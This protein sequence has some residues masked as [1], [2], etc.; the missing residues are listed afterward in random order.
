MEMI[1]AKTWEEAVRRHDASF[2]GAFVYAVR[3]TGIYCRPGCPSRAP[4]PE[5][6]TFFSTPEAAEAAGFRACKKCHPHADTKPQNAMIARVCRQIEQAET[7]LSLAELAG[8]A[9]LSP[10]H[11]HRKFRAATGLTPK[12]YAAAIRTRREAAALQTA[13]SVTEALYEAGY[14]SASRFYDGA[15][16]RLGMSPRAV[17]Q[18]GAAQKIRV[19]TA[20][21]S[22]GAVLVAATETGLCA[23]QLGDDAA[24]LR[25]DFCARFA[26]ADISADPRLAALV[27]DVVT[28]IETPGQAR[29]L[30]LDIRGTAF[31]RAVW[32]ALQ[33]IP[34][35][36]TS[37]YSKIAA[38]LGKP[39]AV[40]AVA[41]A[42]ATNELAIAIPC[43]R[44]VRQD[45]NLAGYRWGL[46]RKAA[47]LGREKA[48]KEK[49]SA[50]FC[51]QKVAKKLC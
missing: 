9:G 18:R 28:L 39:N 12:A 37:T 17:R 35:G 3:T 49:G 50:T 26:N 1:E 43:H 14:G 40:R 23:V 25:A 19:A 36:A 42:C 6:L 7:P 51:E 21:T 29:N 48:D 45:G 8:I 11:F 31:Q 2:D 22:L 41:R 10:H 5:N 46:A 32:E 15:K 4:R 30:P 24:K 16:T 20:P 47:L 33:K 38:A 27:S 34:P 13:G 44:V